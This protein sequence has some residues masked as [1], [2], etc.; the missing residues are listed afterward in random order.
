MH[1][2]PNQLLLAVSA[3]LT[4][5]VAALGGNVELAASPEH[6]LQMLTV[7]PPKFRC[8]LVWPGYANHPASNV[9]MG[10]DQMEIV[11]QFAN[12]L[13]VNPA[14]NAMLSRP[15]G[16][17]PQLTIIDAVRRMV[18]AL[19]LPVDAGCDP[20]GYT[21]VNSQWLTIENIATEQHQLTFTLERAL[22][23]AETIIP[24]TIS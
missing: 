20:H 14:Q 21:L 7:S 19:R 10:T 16:R 22:P 5:P 24:V 17:S 3:A 23:G 4:A 9:G 18:C 1:P 6:A 2:T 13:H 12:G 11:L 8:I 15:N